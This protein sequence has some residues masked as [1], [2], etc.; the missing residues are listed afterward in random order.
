VQPTSSLAGDRP[1]ANVTSS[2]WSFASWGAF[3][4][5]VAA[6]VLFGAAFQLMRSTANDPRA[7]VW[8]GV[9]SLVG[10]GAAYWAAWLWT[11]LGAVLGI[12]G[13]IRPEHRTMLGG[14]ALTANGC[15]AL[16]TSVPILVMSP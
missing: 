5:A 14:A 10:L 4:L 9:I 16:V 2:A 6:F 7:G 13:V 15:I 12:I 3:S 8:M 1:S 11:L